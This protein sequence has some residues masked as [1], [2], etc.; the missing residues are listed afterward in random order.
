MLSSSVARGSEVARVRI[1]VPDPGRVAT[2]ILHDPP[3]ILTL[4]AVGGALAVTVILTGTRLLV[5][6]EQAVISSSDWPWTHDGVGV[7]PV[8]PGGPFRSGDVVLAMNGVPL[9]TWAADAFRLPWTAAAT[10]PDAAP[11]ARNSVQ[12]D[13]RR[14][15]AIVSI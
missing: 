6:S 3:W 1:H 7:E 4:L 5:P 12:F 8:V 11:N 2:R 14:D 13:V 10:P 15:G 9:G